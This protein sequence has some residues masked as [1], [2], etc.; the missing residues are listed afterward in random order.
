MLLH[1]AGNLGGIG[2]FKIAAMLETSGIAGTTW[3]VLAGLF[4][5]PWVLIIS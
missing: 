5:L 1:S 3:G 4:F 2:T